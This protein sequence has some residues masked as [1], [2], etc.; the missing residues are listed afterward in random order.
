[1]GT[2]YKVNDT[3]N[4]H[5][6]GITTLGWELT[7]SNALEEK[8][9]PCRDILI[10]K[11]T[12]GNLLY[13]FLGTI[14]PMQ[15][16]SSMLEIGGGYGFLTRDFL[17]KN[18]SLKASMVDISNLLLNHQRET[19]QGHDVNFIKKDFF[20][21]DFGMFNAFDLVLMNE[22]IGDFITVCD[23]SPEIFNWPDDGNDP[24]IRAI[25]CLYEEYRFTIPGT[26]FN[27]NLGALEAV[28]RLCSAGIKYIYISEHSCEA[29]VPE[30]LKERIPVRSTGEPEQIRLMGHDEYTIK[31]SHLEQIAKKL[32][33]RVLRGQYRQIMPFEYSDRLNFIL[34]SHSQKDEHEIIRQFVEDLFK[35]EFLIIA[36]GDL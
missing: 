10:N 29:L 23:I 1:M 6:S 19:L 31:F 28:E 3:R 34:T 24:V 4:Y 14:I 15:N 36:R 12:F 32:N 9:S 25:R 35:Y 20:D 27:V 5:V 16:I 7:I 11:D 22:I 26:V 17:G 30:E 13:D 33:Y 8:N 21:I 18:P 2:Q